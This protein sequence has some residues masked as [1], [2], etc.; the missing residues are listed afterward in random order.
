MVRPRVVSPPVEPR[1]AESLTAVPLG[2]DRDV[3]N[4]DV[5]KD[6]VSK[7]EPP[8]RREESSL[9]VA[10]ARVAYEDELSRAKERVARDAERQVEIARR[11]V[12]EDFIEVLDDLERALDAPTSA[13]E[14]AMQSGVEMVRDRFL[15]KLRAHGVTRVEARGATFD[16]RFHEAVSV[17]RVA[18]EDAD[19][20][21]EVLRQG[22][23]IG[24]DVLRPAAV[25]VGRPE[26]G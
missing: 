3:S 16:P 4:D 11:H 14:S 6:D 26:V 12:I 1:R 8:R 7:H 21:V 22:Y 9:R 20:V 19:R 13:S 2:V 24:Q 18:P 15:A 5:S 23:V 10:K 17:V 25:V